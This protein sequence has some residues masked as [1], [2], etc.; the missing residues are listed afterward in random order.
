MYI[1]DSAVKLTKVIEIVQVQSFNIA[2]GN[3]AKSPG[4]I[5]DQELERI[6][7]LD[8]YE[9]VVKTITIDV[10]SIRKDYSV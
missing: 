6:L 9:G 1:G 4:Q 5:L 2:K 3:D 10:D 8:D 7:A